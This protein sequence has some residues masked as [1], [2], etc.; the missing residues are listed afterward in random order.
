M[1]RLDMGGDAVHRDPVQ[2]CTGTHADCGS[3]QEPVID[4]AHGR[5]ACGLAIG[6]AV[7]LAAPGA[8]HDRPRTTVTWVGDI[9]PLVQSRCTRCHSPDGKGPMSL[10]TYEDARPWA[11][12]MREEVLARRMPKWHAARGYGQFAND[13][14]L[15]PF[16]VALIVAWVDG[17]AVRGDPSKAAPPAVPPKPAPPPSTARTV[18]V[19]CGDRPLPVG[20]LLAIRPTLGEGASAGFSV[21]FPGGDQEV[22]A[23]IRDYE[24]EFADTY[25]LESPLVLRR[26]SRLRVDGGA[27][28]RAELTIGTG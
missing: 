12:A 26:G 8:A 19:A 4:R 6:F 7:L 25:W 28:C 11:K 18:I 23:W 24:A 17:G 13:P 1:G 20:R 2:P 5:A 22:V 14:T 27:P 21:V 10:V 9:A 3:R 16:D 15:S